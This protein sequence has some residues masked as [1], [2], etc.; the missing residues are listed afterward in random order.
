MVAIQASHALDARAASELG[1][2]LHARAVIEHPRWRLR[3]LVALVTA[4]ARTNLPVDKLRA[5]LRAGVTGAVCPRP[6]R[7]PLGE[8]VERVPSAA[9]IDALWSRSWAA[10][11]TVAVRALLANAPDRAR[12]L[13]GRV[14]DRHVRYRL[15]RV[16]ATGVLDG[17]FVGNPHDP[18]PASLPKLVAAIDARCTG[19]EVEL[20]PVAGPIAAGHLARLDLCVSARRAAIRVRSIRERGPRAMAGLLLVHA[21]LGRRQLEDACRFAHEIAPAGFRQ[22]AQLA[23]ARARFERGEIREALRVMVAIDQPELASERWALHAEIRLAVRREVEPR[24]VRFADGERAALVGATILLRSGMRT[25][26]AHYL[27]TAARELRGGDGATIELLERSGVQPYEA[28]LASSDRQMIDATC[29][30]MIARRVRTL[31]PLPAPFLDGLAGVPT[32]ITDPRSL[33]RA[34][35]DEGAAWVAPQR[36][37][38]LISAARSCLRSALEQPETWTEDVVAARLRTLVQLGGELGRDAIAKPLATL[39]LSRFALAAIEAL[40]VLDAPLAARIVLTRGR[41]LQVEHALQLVE[42]YRGVPRGFAR[43]WR[44]A[45]TN[46]SDAWLAE[47]VHAWYRDHGVLPGLEVF[48]VVARC[49]AVPPVATLLAGIAEV[50]SRLASEPAEIPAQLLTEPGL[51]QLVQLAHPARVDP[52]ISWPSERWRSLL[53]RASATGYRVDAAMVQRFARLLR[54]SLILPAREVRTRELRVRLL[55]KRADILTYLRF[56]DVGAASC[57][58]SD[59][60]YYSTYGTQADVLALWMDPLAFCFHVERDDRP[61]GFVFGGFARLASGGFAILLNGLYLRARTLDVRE[62]V[63]RAVEQLLAPLGITE[64]AIASSHS[65]AGPLPTDYERR[66]VS[67]TRWR[68]L[69]RGAEPVRTANDDLGRTV[70]EPITTHHLWWRR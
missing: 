34:L 16:L 21:A 17:R 43:G 52:R 42:A 19:A 2:L 3:S 68:A 69:L 66:T 27:A 56:A 14:E 47:L 40:C 28:I 32:A 31:G 1:F 29:A 8:L 49:V 25:S 11:A 61:M 41:E 24:I 5:E 53:V 18:Y 54:H 51:L 55:D 36:R 58:R 7:A 38:V 37:R 45:R 59:S 15:A 10:S 22:R 39:P 62:T 60:Q 9:L 4:L 12:E 57:Y 6:L 48:D 30:A 70:N 23:I 64:L 35:H 67:L 26:N 50:A 46:S 65:G 13:V 63:L 33:E 20:D 44:R